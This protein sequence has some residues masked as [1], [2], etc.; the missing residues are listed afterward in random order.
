[1]HMW[2]DWNGEQVERDF[3]LLAAHNLTVLRVFP[4]WPDFQPL[5]AD[6]GGGGGFRG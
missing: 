4:L 2:R 3:D 5:T 1:M 6:F